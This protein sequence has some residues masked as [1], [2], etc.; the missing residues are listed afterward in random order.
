MK[1]ECKNG[2][3]IINNLFLVF[4]GD[5]WNFFIIVFS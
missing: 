1:Y 4:N 3:R 5:G 2:D